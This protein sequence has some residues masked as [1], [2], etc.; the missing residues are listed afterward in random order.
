MLRTIKLCR[1]LL[2]FVILSCAS[3]LALCLIG[4]WP[5]NRRF[6]SADQ[7]IE[8]FVITDDIHTEFVVPVVSDKMDWRRW[9]PADHFPARQPIKSHLSIGW[10]DRGFY[11]E[12]PTWSDLTLAAALRASFWPTPTV[13]HVEYLDRPEP[14]SDCRRLVLA[15]DNYERLVDHIRGSFDLN[16]SRPIQI[17]GEHYRVTDAFYRARGSYHAFRTCNNWTGRGLRVCGV[18]CGLW[19]PLPRAVM[20]HL[21]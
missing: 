15:P 5:V 11:L 1:Y 4:L 20:F 7:G 3:Y 8:I 9:F 18:K 10:G 16:H 6:R 17:V 21:E 14:A 19:T 12:T 13:V 2:L